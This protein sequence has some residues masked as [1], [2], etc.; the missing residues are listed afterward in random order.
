LIGNNAFDKGE[1]V[2]FEWFTNKRP[3]FLSIVD[4][5][6]TNSFTL[7]HV[8]WTDGN[9]NVRFIAWRR[10]AVVGYTGSTGSVAVSV[11][12]AVNL[13]NLTGRSAGDKIFIFAEVA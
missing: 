10:G 11:N 8:P 6:V 7:E 9:G 2:M 5:A 3:Q 4:D 12:K 1:G 13:T